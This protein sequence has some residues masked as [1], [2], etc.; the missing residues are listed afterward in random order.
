MKNITLAIEEQVLEQVRLEAVERRTTVNG[1][2]RDFLNSISAKR[3]AKDDA[4]EALLRLARET[5]GDMG[6]Q[7]W[8]REAL[9]DR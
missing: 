4:R 5:D 8:D 2:V 6:T 3:R 9:Y 7:K 1:L